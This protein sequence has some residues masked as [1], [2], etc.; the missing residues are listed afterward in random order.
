MFSANPLFSFNSQAWWQDAPQL[1]LDRGYARITARGEIVCRR[2]ATLEPDEWLWVLAHLAL[3]SG[4]GHL[5]AKRP[6]STAGDAVACLEVNRFLRESHVGREA[7]PLPEEL[8]R[9]DR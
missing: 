4:L 3:H 1:A 2:G 8:P 9:R 7:V 5:D 6:R